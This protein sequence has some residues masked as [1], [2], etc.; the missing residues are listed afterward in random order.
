MIRRP[1]GNNV[2]TR[3]SSSGIDLRERRAF[4]TMQGKRP[5]RYLLRNIIKT[6]ANVI[7]V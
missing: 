3:R 6:E 1:T 7:F 5:S 4:D 2:V